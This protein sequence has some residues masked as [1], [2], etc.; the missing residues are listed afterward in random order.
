MCLAAN[1]PLIESGTAGYL[2]QATVIK[3]GSTECFECQ[4][5]PTPTTFPICTIRSTPTAPI[6]CTVWAK[7]YLFAQL[8]DRPDD[9]DTIITSDEASQENGR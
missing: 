3:H 8:F 4:P 7:N 5:K 1:V 9:D 6:H 2:G